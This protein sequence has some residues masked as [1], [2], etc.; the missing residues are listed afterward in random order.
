MSFASESSL[1]LFVFGIYIYI[2]LVCILPLYVRRWYV[3]RNAFTRP[4]CCCSPKRRGSLAL[5]EP[6]SRF[7]D[8]PFKFQVVCP[9][10]GTAVLKGLKG[11]SHEKH[12]QLP[13]VVL[14]GRAAV[15]C[16]NNFFRD[17]SELVACRCNLRAYLPVGCFSPGTHSSST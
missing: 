15:D 7:G 1:L 12:R 17:V 14:F 2:Y 16:T 6:E 8:K 11:T 9:Q 13:P 10:N 3:W 4:P 5:L